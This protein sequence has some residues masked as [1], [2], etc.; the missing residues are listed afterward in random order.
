MGEDLSHL[1]KDLRER[2]STIWAHPALVEFRKVLSDLMDKA[3]RDDFR[4]CLKGKIPPDIEGKIFYKCKECS[5]PAP[6][7][8][9]VL[10]ARK[11]GL[12]R[13]FEEAWEKVPEDIKKEL[14][15]ID[16]LWTDADRALAEA[17][18][19]SL[20]ISELYHLCVEGEFMEVARRLDI[21]FTPT[22]YRDCMSCV[23]KFKDLSTAYRKMWG[24][25]KK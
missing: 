21:P 15:G 3:T 12:G 6:I 11:Y 13:K 17:V 16:D 10:V 24:K 5:L 1:R 8:C 7:T 25:R 19:G 18:A 23:A 9:L 22:N 14:R 2:M 20:D 4:N